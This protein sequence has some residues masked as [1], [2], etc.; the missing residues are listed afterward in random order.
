MIFLRGLFAMIEIGC[1]SF[2]KTLAG[3][4]RACFVL[5][6]LASCFGQLST[7]QGTFEERI[8]V[9]E[10]AFTSSKV[11]SLLQLYSLPARDASVSDFDAF[12][13]TYL[14]GVLATDDRRQFDLATMEFVAKLHNGH[15][16]F[17]D[18]GLDKSNNQ[19]LA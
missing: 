5:A 2:G 19:P 4:K 1:N 14:A 15:T 10:R 3:M 16:F 9:D 11:Y 18:T 13:K 12:Y 8:G 7:G 17:W 6:F